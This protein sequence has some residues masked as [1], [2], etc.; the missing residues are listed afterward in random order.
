MS[1]GHMLSVGSSL[2][3]FLLCGKQARPSWAL[4]LQAFPALAMCDTW[5]YAGADSGRFDGRWEVGGGRW[6]ALCTEEDSVPNTPAP[7]VDELAARVFRRGCKRVT[8]PS[9]PPRGLHCNKEGPGRSKP[10]RIARTGG[11]PSIWVL[12]GF[13]FAIGPGRS[14]PELWTTAGRSALPCSA[15][16]AWVF[17]ARLPYSSWQ[18]EAACPLV[19]GLSANDGGHR[20]R[21]SPQSKTRPS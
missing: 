13:L 5:S 18:S 1:A 20:R 19:S 7:P 14:L 4:L 12:D 17:S 16:H 6:E 15:C 2:G 21:L 10:G 11:T 8:S 9:P 3:P